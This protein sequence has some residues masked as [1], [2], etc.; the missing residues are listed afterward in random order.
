[1]PLM[2]FGAIARPAD[3]SRMDTRV[4]GALHVILTPLVF[5]FG[6]AMLRE[7]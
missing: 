3:P 6:W 5:T 2:G 4:R 7:W 1:M